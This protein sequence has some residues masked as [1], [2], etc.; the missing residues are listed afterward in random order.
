MR[1]KLNFDFINQNY[2]HIT[3]KINQIDIMGTNV[4]VNLQQ[5]YAIVDKWEIIFA[6]AYQTFD[7]FFNLFEFYK[8]FFDGVHNISS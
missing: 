1:K 2:L 4:T 7:I 8:R 3:H 5:F 6:N